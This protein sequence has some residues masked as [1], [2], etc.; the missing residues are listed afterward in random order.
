MMPAGYAS[1]GPP[2]NVGYGRPTI[3]PTPNFNPNMEAERIRSAIKGSGTSE[4]TI[5]DIFGS[6]TS[7]E[8]K[9]IDACYKTMFGSMMMKD[10]ENELKLSGSFMKILNY[11]FFTLAEFDAH[12]VHKSVTGPRT[13]E[14]ALIEIFTTRNNQQIRE[15][16]EAYRRMFNRDLEKDVVSDL[17]GNF[18]NLMTSLI[19]GNRDETGRLDQ[20]AAVADA[21]N[22]YNSGQGRWGTDDL[23]LNN[24]FVTRSYPQLNL[25]FNEYSKISKYDI[26]QSIDKELSG[27]FKLAMMS[28][29]KSARDRPGFFAERLYNSMKGLGSDERT[30]NRII[31]SRCEIDLED[32]KQSYNT[33]FN[34]DLN[35]VVEGDTKGDYQR[36]LLQ[37]LGNF[38]T[39][40]TY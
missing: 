8:L 16:V 4:S 12:N 14:N 19:Q 23:T 13:D 38:R 1:Y 33:K 39:T 3:M 2:S 22:I 9:Q 40:P 34:K 36:I 26:E 11:R 32:I 21:N 31:V 10:L 5:I 25:I 15:A 20:S 18:K 35:K 27:N 30:L 28:I 29:I 24:I 37:I 6:R 17:S 7:M